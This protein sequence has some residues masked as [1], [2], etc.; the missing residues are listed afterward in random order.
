MFIVCLVLLFISVEGFA[1]CD[2]TTQGDIDGSGSVDIADLVY[3]VAYS[4]DAGTVPENNPDCPLVNNADLNCDNE[5]NITD[6]VY[7]VEYSFNNGLQPCDYCLIQNFPTPEIIDSSIVTQAW[8]LYFSV[9]DNNN[10]VFIYEN[11]PGSVTKTHTASGVFTTY[12]TQQ[13]QLNKNAVFHLPKSA[14]AQLR[15]LPASNQ[16]LKVNA[17]LPQLTLTPS[18]MDTN[19][20]EIP[21]IPFTIE[22]NSI[23]Y[24]TMMESFHGGTGLTPTL[25]EN[26]LEII[27]SAPASPTV[28]EINMNC[29]ADSLL[30]HASAYAVRHNRN[31]EL[32]GFDDVYFFSYSNNFYVLNI[33]E[34]DCFLEQEQRYL[35]IFYNYYYVNTITGVNGQT[36]LDQSQTMVF[37]YQF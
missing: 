3:L 9:F 18:Y 21:V 10:T 25:E 36:I 16:A 31:Y 35:L 24:D 5:V 19:G 2:C 33:S 14:L 12:Y 8:D 20:F 29:S 6:I 17:K 4:F 13:T 22:D 7:L 26:L 27:Q 23:S 30:I 1:Q 34:Y 32:F 28:D 37:K 15:E 11:Y